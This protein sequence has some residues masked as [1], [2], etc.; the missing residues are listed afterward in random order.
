MARAARLRAE[1]AARFSGSRNGP[2]P[3]RGRARAGRGP[4]HQRRGGRPARADRPGALRFPFA[5]QPGGAHHAGAR[6]VRAAQHGRSR[7]P[8]P[9]ASAVGGVRPAPRRRAPRRGH[10]P[11]RHGTPG[12]PAGGP[13]RGFRHVHVGLR[14]RDGLRDDRREGPAEPGAGGLRGDVRPHHGVHRLCR[15]G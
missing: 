7:P 10:R 11:D 15:P 12:G 13:D 8:G 6:A 1:P 4:R 14:Q 3:R 2:P 9:Q 5:G